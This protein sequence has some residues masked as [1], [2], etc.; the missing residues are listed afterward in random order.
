GHDPLYGARVLLTGAV[1]VSFRR[2]Y[3]SLWRMPTLTAWIVGVAVGVAWLLGPE[4]DSAPPGHGV[5]PAWLVASWLAF[6][7]LGAVVV[8]P[9][10]EELAFRGYLARRLDRAEFW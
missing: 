9:L 6:R 1:L 5:W 2:S 7:S 3:R 10:C 8:V 4:A